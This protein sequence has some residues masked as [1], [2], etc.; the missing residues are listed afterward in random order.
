MKIIIAAEDRDVSAFRITKQIHSQK[1]K[2]WN[3]SNSY[4]TSRN[5]SCTRVNHQFLID[6]SITRSS[7]S[8][9]NNMKISRSVVIMD[10]FQN[11]NQLESDW[12]N[13]K[14]RITVKHISTVIACIKY[15]WMHNLVKVTLWKVGRLTIL[16]AII[17]IIIA[18]MVI[19]KMSQVVTI[20]KLNKLVI[21]L[22]FTVTIYSNRWCFFVP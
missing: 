14:T 4:C 3:K 13:N 2:Y 6:C 12:D 16:V 22:C 15:I 21:I 10:I 8:S 11:V 7:S 18:I 9:S 20:I 1:K 17:I 19:V 5:N